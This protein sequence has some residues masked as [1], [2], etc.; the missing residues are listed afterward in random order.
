MAN[1][2]GESRRQARPK[3]IY[4]KAQACRR[5]R[6]GL[7]VHAPTAGHVRAD[8]LDVVRP[9]FGSRFWITPPL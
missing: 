6:W 2:E 5:C 7:S 3:R 4:E 8:D 1:R 9:V